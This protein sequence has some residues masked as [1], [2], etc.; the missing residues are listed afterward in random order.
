[1]PGS[2]HRRD[3]LES[4]ARGR[5]TRDWEMKTTRSNTDFFG[6]RLYSA[7]EANDRAIVETVTAL[8]NDRGVPRAQVALAW[9]LGT[10][11]MTAPI[12][13]SSK[14]Q[15]LQDA[16]AALDLQLTAEERARLEAPYVPHPVTGLR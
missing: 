12:I 3:S 2:G 15:H 13:G 4:L 10:P 8:A 11:G 5:L 6:Q 16:S 9:L 1:M 7:M 14:L